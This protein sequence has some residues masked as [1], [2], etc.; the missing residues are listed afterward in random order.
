MAMTG[1]DSPE[2]TSTKLG[3]TLTAIAVALFILGSVG[4]AIG[5]GFQTWMP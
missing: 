4:T 2:F 1:T 5:Y 3:R